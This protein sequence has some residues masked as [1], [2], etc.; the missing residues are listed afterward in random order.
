MLAAIV[1]AASVTHISRVTRAGGALTGAT[2]S[3]PPARSADRRRGRPGLLL[4][5]PREVIDGLESRSRRD[6]PDGQAGVGQQVD[7][8]RDATGWRRAF[9]AHYCNA[10]SF[11]PGTTSRSTPAHGQRASHPRARDDP[12]P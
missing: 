8:D 6:V 2:L 4:D 3:R 11:V 5:A 9:V 1:M 10:R 7:A 12:P